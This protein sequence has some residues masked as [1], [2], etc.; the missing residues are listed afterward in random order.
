MAKSK[1]NPKFCKLVVKYGKEGLSRATVASKLGIGRRTLYDWIENP[2]KYPEFS[3][4]WEQYETELQS[5]IDEELRKVATGEMKLGPGGVAALIY[6]GRVLLGHKHVEYLIDLKREQT[7]THTPTP[8]QVKEELKKFLEM[9]NLLALI[10]D[11]EQSKRS[12]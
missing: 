2:I 4:A 8:T 10:D 5:S 12:N 6:R 9:G 11:S 1:Y 3:Q 7:I